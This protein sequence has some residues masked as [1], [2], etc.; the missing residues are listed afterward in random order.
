RRSVAPA[1]AVLCASAALLTMGNGLAGTLVS[2]RADAEGFAPVITG[3]VMSAYFAGFV[4]GSFAVPALV[5]RVGHIRTF[6]AMISLA[7]S[8]ALAYALW[9]EPG[10]WTLLRFAQGACLAGGIM[11]IESWLN[12][13]ATRATRGR[14]LALYGVVIFAAWSLSQLWLAAAPVTGFVLFVAVSML[15]SAAMLPLLLAD[16]RDPVVATATR[17]PLAKLLVTSPLAVVA[18]FAVGFATGATLSLGPVYAGGIGLDEGGVSLFMAAL[19]VGAMALEWPLGAGSDRLDRRWVL[20]LAA[21]AGG[22]AAA[23]LAAQPAGHWSLLAAAFA[24]G[25]FTIPL[26]SVAVAHA[27]DYARPEE[28]VAVS[29]GLLIVYGCGSIVGPLV[30]G[31]ALDRAGPGAVFAVAAVVMVATAAFA[32]VRMTRRPTVTATTGF[33]SRPRTTHAAADLD[34]RQEADA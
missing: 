21:I 20:T 10:F 13:I 32:L 1:L 19:L 12:A 27:S 18:C 6:A 29:S 31:V 2:V 9:I 4:A 3:A 26:Y 34:P 28:T 14:I 15:K 30:G 8:V 25:G 22:L 16:V 11:V 23:A 17:A 5:R 33:V 24:Y 7:S